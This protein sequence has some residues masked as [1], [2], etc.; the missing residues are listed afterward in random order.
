[1]EIPV[2]SSCALFNTIWTSLNTENT[3]INMVVSNNNA[4]TCYMSY[5][6]KPGPMMPEYEIQKYRYCD[7]LWVDISCVYILV[8]YISDI[9]DKPLFI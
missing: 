9:G 4:G 7:L 1:M 8:P 5:P 3:A 6:P 2:L